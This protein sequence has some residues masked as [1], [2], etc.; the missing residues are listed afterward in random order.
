MGKQ[1]IELDNLELSYLLGEYLEDKK[2]NIPND[3]PITHN[4]YPYF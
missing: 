3:Y 4:L 1:L 2:L